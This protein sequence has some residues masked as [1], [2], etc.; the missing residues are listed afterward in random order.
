[1]KKEIHVSE[2][3]I[4][5]RLAGLVA[6]V[7]VA[8][9][10]FTLAVTGLRQKTEGYQQVEGIAFREAPLYQSGVEL[11]YY[12]SGSSAEIRS[13]TNAL[14]ALYSDAL[15]RSYKLL[16][17]GVEFEDV[18]NP[19]VLN[20]RRG[21]PT[22]VSEELFAVL[23][24]AYEKTCRQ[25]GYNMFA[26]A[27]YAQWE[28]LRNQSD[29]ADLDPLRS[30]EEAALLARLA[31]ETGRLDHFTL[32]LDPARRTVLFDV[33][34]AY[35]AL[36]SELGIDAPVLD[37]NLLH[38]AYELSLVRDA[39]VSQGWVR[40]Y[41]A[42]DSGLAISLPEQ[43]PGEYSFY[44]CTESGV[45][46]AARLPVTPGSAASQFRVFAF[47]PGETEYYTVE[48][49]SGTVYRHPYLT[50]AGEYTGVLMSAFALSEDGDAPAACYE[51]IRLFAQPDAA[52]VQAVAGHSRLPLAWTMQGEEKT[53]HTN[54]P[55]RFAAAEDYG[56]TLD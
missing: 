2:K 14:K 35:C 1:M 16:H 20:A 12:F 32:E 26:G 48:D 51:N 34:E 36:L 54:A 40:G 10:A 6:A 5:L 45:S 13:E 39:L 41:L 43:L 53:V 47:T 42:C 38:D 22:E 37:L 24:D 28:G 50:A 18:I 52:R 44:G 27:L 3:N 56:W 29:A 55:D 4:P 15:C 17:S 46:P 19:A 9:A 11:M 7:A 49:G 30:G 31:E 33:D 23:A 21:Q 25:E 8:V